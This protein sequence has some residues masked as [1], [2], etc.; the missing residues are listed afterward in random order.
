MGTK[1]SKK[2]FLRGFFFLGFFIVLELAKLA[3]FLIG[4][5]KH[6]HDE[7]NYCS[8]GLTKHGLIMLSVSCLYCCFSCWKVNQ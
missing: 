1:I 3:K 6:T 7:N 8:Q 4:I 5:N 2:K